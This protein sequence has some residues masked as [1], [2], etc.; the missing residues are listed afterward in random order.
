MIPLIRLAGYREIQHECREDIATLVFRAQ[1]DAD[2]YKDQSDWG[3]IVNKGH[4]LEFAKNQEENA[5]RE[6][7]SSWDL[8]PYI[9][10]I[11]EAHQHLAESQ[12]VKN[13]SRLSTK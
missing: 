8:G 6:S 9:T 11:E 3:F 5:S 2:G 12:N 7:Q 4:Q 1:L 10:A 13:L